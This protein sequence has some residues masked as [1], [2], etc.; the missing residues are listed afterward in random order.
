MNVNHTEVAQAKKIAEIMDSLFVIPGT[1]WRI[2]LDPV[3]GLIPGFGDFVSNAIGLYPILL[4]MKYRISKAIIMRMVV[5]LAGDYLIG[6]IP[7]IGDLFDALFKANRKN[8]D[9]LERGLM[10]PGRTKGLSVLFLLFI[11]L[12][13]TSIL[14][15][16]LVLLILLLAQLS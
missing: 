16:P 1:K 11:G 14:V 7:L 15:A 2:G 9:L 12:V 6:S 3:L 8:T 5:N 10:E 4:G 13:L